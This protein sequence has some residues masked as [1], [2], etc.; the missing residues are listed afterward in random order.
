MPINSQIKKTDPTPVNDGEPV[1]IIG[2][3]CRFPGGVNNLD[4]FWDLLKN[5]V[6]AITDIPSDRFDANAFFDPKP[7]M[8]GKICSPARWIPDR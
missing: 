6:D 4:S 1:A 2:I 8:P 3:G 7:A 5:G